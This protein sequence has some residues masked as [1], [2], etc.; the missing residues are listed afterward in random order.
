VVAE[1]AWESSFEKAIEAVRRGGFEEVKAAMEVLGFVF[2][3]TGDANH[4]IYF[5]PELR[6]DRHFRYPRNFYRPHGPRRSSDRISRHDQSQA[7]Q[8]IEALIEARSSQNS[9]G[10]Y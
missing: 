1:R 4:W 2:R 3:T 8:M 10:G 9:G 6:G 5:H 7:K